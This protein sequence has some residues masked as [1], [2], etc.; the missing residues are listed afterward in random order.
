MVVKV[1]LEGLNVV[2]AR[3][4]WYV[5]VRDTK[6]K[7]LVG[8]EGSRADLDKRMAMPDFIA[9]YNSRRVRDLRRTYPDGT[10]GALVEWYE[11]E[12]PK[13]QSLAEATKNDYTKA[14]KYLRPEFDYALADIT[15]A[16]LYDIRDKCA[17]EKWPRFADKMISALSSM[18]TQ[19]VKRKKMLGNPALGIDKCHKADPNAN[20]EWRK[21]EWDYVAANAPAHLL[22]PMMIARHAGYRG[23]TIVKLRWNDYQPDPRFGKCFRIITAKNKE[24][25]WIPATD[26]LQAYLDKL[27]RPALNICTRADGTPWESEV[28]M[29]TSV[30]H[31]LRDLEEAGHIGGGTTLHGLRTT[32]AAD[33]KR[34]GAETGDVAAALGDKSERMGAH[35]T[36]HVENEAKV[37][38]AFEGKKKR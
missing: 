36:R 16:D 23:Q 17:K 8:F 9:K 31:Y 38:R 20:R 22:T 19:A 27:D 11:N 18:F 15:Q 33:L 24:L 2:C 34:S 4:K 13:Y 26:E 25:V 10:L 14:F 28:Q 7:L 30:S 21:N 37:I 12:C 35:Y 29:Q 6:E 3:G 1:K 32:Y 5:Y